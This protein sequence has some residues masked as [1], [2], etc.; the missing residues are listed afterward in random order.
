MSWFPLSKC[1]EYICVLSQKYGDLKLVSVTLTKRRAQF[2]GHAFR[3]KGGIISDIRLW[4]VSTGRNSPFLISSQEMQEY[5]L[6]TFLQPWQIR[7]FG[8]KLWVTSRPRPQ[9]DDDDD[10]ICFISLF[11]PEESRFFEYSYKRV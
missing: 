5:S 3:T 10:G 4:K 6:R 2:V 11:R 8:A 7:L 9:D 1:I